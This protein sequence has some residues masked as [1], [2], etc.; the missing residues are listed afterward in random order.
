MTM[1][2]RAS[3]RR[4]SRSKFMGL[5]CLAIIGFNSYNPVFRVLTFEYAFG[6]AFFPSPRFPLSPRRRLP[7]VLELFGFRR[8]LH[9]IGRFWRR[10]RA[11]IVNGL[12]HQK[13][14]PK[15]R[16]YRVGGTEIPV[17]MAA[18]VFLRQGVLD[19]LLDLGVGN[20]EALSLGD[21][22]QRELEPHLLHR[23][24]A[25]L[26]LQH[27]ERG[28]RVPEVSLELD[29]LLLQAQLQLAHPPVDL[30]VDERLR[31]FGFHPLVER[32]QHVILEA[33]LVRLVRRLLQFVVHLLPQFRQ[34]LAPSHLSSQLVL[35]G[36]QP[37]FLDGL[38]GDPEDH[39]RAREIFLWVVGRQCQPDVTALP[40][41]LPGETFGEP[42]DQ[43]L[44][45]HLELGVGLAFA[46][47][48]RAG[49]QDVGV[50]RQEIPGLHRALDG[51]QLGE[52]STQALDGL[53][54]VDVPDLGARPWHPDVLVL[55]EGDLR[56]D[57]YRG[58]EP[59]RLASV[60][61]L[62]LDPG[63]VN[64][65]EAG[66]IEGRVV[67]G[68][69]QEIERFLAECRPAD[70]PL[71]HRPGRLSRAESSDPH[72]RR[73]PGVGLIDRFRNLVG[74]DFDREYDLRT[75]F[76]LG[77]DLHRGHGDLRYQFELIPTTSKWASDRKVGLS[78]SC[79][80]LPSPLPPHFP[81]ALGDGRGGVSRHPDNFF[82]AAGTRTKNFGALVA[83][84]EIR[85]TRATATQLR[86]TTS[87][88]ERGETRPYHADEGD[89]L[90]L[91]VRFSRRTAGERTR[92]SMAC[93]TR[94]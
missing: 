10:H 67:G 26:R 3:G 57:R 4:L 49:F 91:G 54:D 45:V 94:P 24:W 5:S 80:S 48:Y 86:A 2:M 87:L 50:N 74:V 47:Q 62:D 17:S 65:V 37:A 76:P 68:G 1:G 30:A 66:F 22:F 25:L 20:G 18:V 93:A 82:A 15:V 35:K 23:L 13:L 75:R 56:L 14:V 38:H 78:L 6:S 51:M 33:L 71:D 32:L 72:P 21:G 9:C 85:D 52:S 60:E 89:T 44:L 40:D 88:P 61:L 39:V 81:P 28:V 84:A 41:R 55:L 77:I 83:G 11:Q 36:W 43:T 73:E 46:D 70:F 90:S 69:Q 7:H 8:R 79:T 16:P 64:R 58:G 19:G 12:S 27:V 34:R 53:V 29:A 31:D 63:N 59:H 42:G 92:T